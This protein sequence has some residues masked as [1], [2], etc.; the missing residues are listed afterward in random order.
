MVKSMMNQVQQERQDLDCVKN[1]GDS[2]I[3]FLFR[4]APSLSN[5]SVERSFDL[6][7]LAEFGIL[8]A[9]LWCPHPRKRNTP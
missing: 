5:P 7:K 1:T 8:L 6:V 4:F 2:L 3:T 9:P